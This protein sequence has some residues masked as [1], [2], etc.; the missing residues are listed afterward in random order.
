MNRFF[1]PQIEAGILDQEESHHAAHVLRLK[2]GSTA[3][4]FNGKGREAHVRFKLVKNKEVSFEILQTSQTPL[5]KSRLA[6]AQAVPKGKAMDLIIQKATELGI[7]EIW[8]IL[9]DR[10]V[11]HLDSERVESKQEKW[12]QI[13]IEACK[14]CG[15]N[16]LPKIHAAMNMEKF[17]E[18]IPG[19][20]LKLIASLQPDARSLRQILSKTPNVPGDVF[21][22]IGPEGDFTPSEIG[23][24]R[25]AGFA[26][27][28]LGPT[29]LRTETASLFMISVL[30]YEL[31]LS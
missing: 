18:Q 22:M 15:Q 14:Q 13:A 5:P 20:S 24:A 3:N 8:P 2:E 23:H 17:L 7:H 6:L 4:I 26:P 30:T 28:S 10:S 12:Q 16:W 19:N 25:S 31:Q 11:V 27:V 29:I 21:F 9:S 1:C